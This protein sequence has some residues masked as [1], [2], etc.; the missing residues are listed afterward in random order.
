[1]P[2]LFITFQTALKNFFFFFFYLSFSKHISMY[3]LRKFVAEIKCNA[4]F[5]SEV[6]L[7]IGISDAFSRALASQTSQAEA[8]KHLSV[9]NLLKLSHF[10]MFLYSFEQ[11]H[12]AGA[13]ASPDV[14]HMR[15]DCAS[16][17]FWTLWMEC[18]RMRTRTRQIYT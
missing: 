11:Q 5:C 3:I 10:C 18:R 17:L 4:S 7:K 2:H 16:P 8:I 12:V 6:I 14:C 15:H 13:A 1:M 9:P